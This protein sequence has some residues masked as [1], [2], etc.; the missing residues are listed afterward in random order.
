MTKVF[1]SYSRKDLD[2]V[3]CLAKDLEAAG[4]EVWYDLRPGG[5]HAQGDGNLFI[6]FDQ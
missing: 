6:F 4:L 5:G 1:I 2:F 3:E